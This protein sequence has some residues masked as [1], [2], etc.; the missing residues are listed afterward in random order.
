MSKY[1][2][3]LLISIASVALP[4]PASRSAERTTPSALNLEAWA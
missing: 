4:S 2:Q 1:R 3:A